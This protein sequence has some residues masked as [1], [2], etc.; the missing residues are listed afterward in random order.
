MDAV[1]LKD[2]QTWGK[3]DPY[4]KV[5][6]GARTRNERDAH[7]REASAR[8]GWSASR[9]ASTGPRPRSTSEVWNS[10]TLTSNNIIG[11]GSISLDEVFARGVHEARCRLKDKKGTRPARANSSIVL[12]FEWAKAQAHAAADDGGMMSPQQMMPPQQ[13][14]SPQQMMP[15]RQMM[16]P[17]AMLPAST[18]AS[19]RG[20]A[21]QRDPPRIWASAPSP[22]RRHG[23]PPHPHRRPMRAHL[24]AG[25]GR[26][27]RRRER[28]PAATATVASGASRAQRRSAVGGATRR[29]ERARDPG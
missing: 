20:N 12:R 6:C 19:P 22:E 18:D 24:S 1:R 9:S 7:G 25:S 15:P 21:R 27:V 13:M 16:P 14:M 10:N 4:V 23:Y 26:S 29:G 28:K 5:Q 11:T 17:P 2:T 8:D 3:Q